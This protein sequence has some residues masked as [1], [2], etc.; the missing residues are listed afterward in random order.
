MYAYVWVCLCVCLCVCTRLRVCLC[1]YVCLCVLVFVRVFA[2]TRLCVCGVCVC[3]QN[4]PST[5]AT[6]MTLVT[7]SI[8]DVIL[9]TLTSF[10]CHLSLETNMTSSATVD[11]DVINTT[12]DL[13]VSSLVRA[14]IL[15]TW[16][17]S[18]V[19]VKHHVTERVT[20][21][22]A[23]VTLTLTW[24]YNGAKLLLLSEHEQLLADR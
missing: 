19:C 8:A 18:A 16:V 10:Q 4:L 6:A 21:Y 1:L 24:M 17:A 7:W 20:Y 23:L 12:L 9:N 13:W 5:M 22:A 15:I 14:L 11:T 3:V 2:R